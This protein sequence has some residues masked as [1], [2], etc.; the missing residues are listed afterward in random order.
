MPI[1]PAG[2]HFPVDGGAIV[3]LVHFVEGQ[4]VHIGA[5]G[6]GFRSWLAGVSAQ[7]ANDACFCDTSL[8]LES[9]AA[10]ALCHK[11]RGAYL[12]EPEF[13]VRVLVIKAKSEQVV[14]RRVSTRREA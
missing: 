10:Q 5:D 13:G 8:H 11:T 3:D 4:G 12:L 1:V 9:Q 14:G 2:M 7:Q 6:D